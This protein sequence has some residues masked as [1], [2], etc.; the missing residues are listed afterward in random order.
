VVVFARPG[1]PVPRSSLIAR[2]IQVPAI[3]ISATEV[4]RRAREG[5]SL[6]YWVPDPVAEYVTL[7]RLYLDPA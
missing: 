1:V 6:R 2:T 3:E 7:H 4:R 5:R